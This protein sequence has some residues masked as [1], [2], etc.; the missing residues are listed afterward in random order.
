MSDRLNCSI[1]FTKI[2]PQLYRAGVE[3]F[4][5]MLA[6]TAGNML[7]NLGGIGPYMFQCKELGPGTYAFQAWEL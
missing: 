7:D 1:H 4:F 5:V 2:E 6:T 3:A